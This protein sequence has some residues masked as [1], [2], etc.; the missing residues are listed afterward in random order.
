MNFFLYFAALKIQSNFSINLAKFRF[1]FLLALANCHGISLK[2]CANATHQNLFSLLLHK[3]VLS[4]KIA[5]TLNF[6]Y[7]KVVQFLFTSTSTML[8]KRLSE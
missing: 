2:C 6:C 8:S 1:D 7:I 4:V 3:T 5:M